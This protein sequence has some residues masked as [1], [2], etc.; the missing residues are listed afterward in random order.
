LRQLEVAVVTTN[1]G[2]TGHEGAKESNVPGAPREREVIT[3]DWAN[4]DKGSAG[5]RSP[6]HDDNRSPTGDDSSPDSLPAQ[7]ARGPAI[8]R[9]R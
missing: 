9:H 7:P 5:K 3:P 6:N 8:D 4:L 2:D 1:A